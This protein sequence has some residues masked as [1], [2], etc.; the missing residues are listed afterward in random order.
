MAPG[1]GRGLTLTRLR[2]RNDVR[3]YDDL[4]GSWWD[5]GG[6]LA[7]LHW[8]ADA[9]A[10]LVPPP[11]P[12]DVLVDLGVGGGL[13]ATRVGGYRHIGVDLATS[14]LEV[15]RARGVAPVRADIS[16][17]PL[18]DGCA[19]VVVAGE[20]LEHVEH[21]EAVVEEIARVLRPGGTVVLDTISSTRLARTAI[22]TVAERLPGGPPRHI[23]DPR[24]FVD[25]ARLRRLF[26]AHGIDVHLHGL[27]PSLVD[28]LRFLAQRSHPV[29]MLPTRSLSLV[30]AGVG[31]KPVPGQDGVV[32]VQAR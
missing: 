18:A 17:L 8:L 32:K 3:Q 29:R 30:Y 13:M 23:H 28:Y 7:A 21:L 5:E 9:R 20:I 22:V 6:P 4:V 31:R 10:P 14:A 27:R 11:A 24:L 25:P 1:V 19:G 26:A 15:A 2:A 12:A 16:R